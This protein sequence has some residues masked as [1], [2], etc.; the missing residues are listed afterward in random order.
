MKILEDFVSTAALVYLLFFT[1]LFV[2]AANRTLNLPGVE[3]GRPVSGG[4][5]RRATSGFERLEGL[6]PLLAC[7]GVS[8]SGEVCAVAIAV[9]WLY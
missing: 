3:C 7:P 9:L 8:N 6:R 4:Q 2:T 1:T 5:D